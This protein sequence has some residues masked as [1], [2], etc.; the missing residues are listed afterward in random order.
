[1]TSIRMI[2]LGLVA[3]TV[4]ACSSMDVASRNAPLDVPALSADAQVV[5]RNYAV[6]NITFT[7]PEDL[8]VSER[9]WYYPLADIVW[10]GDPVGDRKEQI[11]AMFYTAAQRGVMQQEGAVPVILDIEL[12]RFHG[13]S[14]R[15]RFSVGGNYNIVFWLS[16]RHAET[17]VLIEDARKVVLNLS[18]PGGSAAILAEQR[19]QT[20]KVRVT[21]YLTQVFK[22]EIRGQVVL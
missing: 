12:I 5:E 10:R 20:E 9:N 22:D 17:G 4:S 18:A 6:Q 15:T 8:S 14:E 19:G 1:M 16:V 13:V 21:D 3:A 7:A 11:G 2:L